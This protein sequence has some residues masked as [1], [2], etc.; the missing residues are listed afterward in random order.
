[1]GTSTVRPLLE[2]N[3]SSFQ[4]KKKVTEVIVGVGVNKWHFIDKHGV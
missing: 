3:K 4:F 1:M 2:R